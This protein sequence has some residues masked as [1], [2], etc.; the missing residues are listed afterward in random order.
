V[1][2][3]ACGRRNHPARYTLTFSGRPYRPR[4][5]F[6]FPMPMSAEAA[7][8]KVR[9]EGREGWREQEY[10]VGEQCAARVMTYHRLRH[11]R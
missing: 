10:H 2:C 9:V 8:R 7:L 5:D 6:S 3:E 1:D 11:Y 4:A